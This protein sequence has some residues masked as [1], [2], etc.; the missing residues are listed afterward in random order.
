LQ[1]LSLPQV[2]YVAW[3]HHYTHVIRHGEHTKGLDVSD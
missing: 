2:S 3:Q 1:L